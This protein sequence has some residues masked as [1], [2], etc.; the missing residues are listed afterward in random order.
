LSDPVRP[1]DLVFTG[2]DVY[3]VDAA[4]RRAEAVAVR[5]GTIVAVGTD[6]DVRGLV[7]PATE[8]VDLRGRLLLPGFQ[9]AHVHA[10]SAGLDRLRIDLSDAHSLEDY[11]ALIKRYADEHRDAE[12]LLGGGWAMDVFPG[13]T[14]TRDVLDAIAPDRPAFINNR[15]NHAAWV[16]ARALELAGVDASTPDPADGRIERDDRG[17]PSGTLHEGAMNLVRRIVPRATL[18]EQLEGL[19]IGQRYLHSLGVTGWQDAIVGEYSTLQDAFDAY[20]TAAGRGLLTARVRGALWFER[21]KGLEQLPFLLDRRERSRVGRFQATSVKIMADGVCEN[22][23]AAML[24]PY[25][26][27]HGHATDNRGIPFFDEVELREAAVALDAEGFQVHVHAIGDRAVRMALD[28][29]EAARA[30]NG[31][32]GN[33][34]HVAHIQVVHPEDVPR[35]GAL[36][37]TANAQPLWAAYEP[38]MSE[39]TIPFIGPERTSWQY[40]FRSLLRS[41]ATMAFGSD[42]PVSSPNPLWEI[43]VAVNREEP[44]DYPYADAPEGPFLPH[45]R[46]GLPEAIA[47]A[48]IGSAYVNHQDDVTGSIEVGKL[49]DLVVLDRDPFEHPPSEI[50]DARVELTFVEGEKVFEAPGR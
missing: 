38:Q 37:V 16:N 36:G 21:G 20:V 22:F 23:T 15:D 17:S 26:D 34:H 8:V 42:W 13:G 45:E 46:L 10:P 3:T 6:A 28:A 49:A 30:A 18:D 25:L 31:V 33:R 7:G 41:G 32:T 35:F 24:E 44:A 5:G 4:R 40:P 29:F 27:G 19:L 12:W 48:T 9:D 14:P 50:A 2:G 47:A 11:R 39:L 43:H 1:A